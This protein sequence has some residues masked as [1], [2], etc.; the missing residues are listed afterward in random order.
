MLI[1]I[2]GL[3]VHA[4]AVYRQWHVY[5][6]FVDFRISFLSN[7]CP[8]FEVGC[9]VLCVLSNTSSTH[10]DVFD[11]LRELAHLLC[12]VGSDLS[13]LQFLNCVDEQI[14]KAILCSVGWDILINISLWHWY[15]TS[16]HK[17]GNGAGDGARHQAYLPTYNMYTTP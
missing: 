5:R 16:S 4:T 3:I 9:L 1:V 7:L 8:K 13:A 14:S 10:I 2:I 12:C 15:I 11:K 6:I 17:A